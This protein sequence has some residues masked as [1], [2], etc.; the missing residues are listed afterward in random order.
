MELEI[1]LRRPNGPGE[2]GLA[3]GGKEIGTV[4]ALGSWTRS[5]HRIEPRSLRRGLNRLTLRWPLALGEGEAALQ[6]AADR[7]ELGVAADLH[8]V[9]G[10]VFSLLARPA[11]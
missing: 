9:F 1:T 2:V 4:E 3:V 8:P 6:A 11:T 10:E 7:L 5:V